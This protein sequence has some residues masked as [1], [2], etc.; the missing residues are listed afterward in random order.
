MSFSHIDVK[1]PFWKQ[2]EFK[3]FFL[4]IGM[5]AAINSQHKEVLSLKSKRNPSLKWRKKK[6][7]KRESLCKTHFCIGASEIWRKPIHCILEEMKNKHNIKWIRITMSYHKFV[8]I[9]EIFQGGLN[10]KLMKG[11]GSRDYKNLPCNC[12]KKLKK[13]SECVYS[14][15][16]RK[17]MVVYQATC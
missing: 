12:I 7:N 10:R 16:C 9:R 11:V 3:C 2:N 1:L 17:H 6:R 8:N 5:E 15:D 13:D 14:D 4:D